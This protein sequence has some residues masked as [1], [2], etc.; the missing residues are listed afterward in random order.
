MKYPKVK[1]KQIPLK[2][3][4][5]V[6]NYF[7]FNANNNFGKYVFM[8]HP[9]LKN[10]KSKKEVE[11]YIIDLSRKNQKVIESSISVFR[12]KWQKVEKDFFNILPEI[13]G[14]EWPQGKIITA[15]V[16]INPISPRFLD[17]WAFSINYKKQSNTSRVKEIFM[18]EI[19]H[20]LY[21]KKWKEVFPKSKR[22]T[23]D[24]PYVE[25]RLSEILA[26][27]IL[28]YSPARKLIGKSADS[29]DEHEKIKIGN[30][31]IVKHFEDLYK[32]SIKQQKSFDEFLQ[33][34]YKEILKYESKF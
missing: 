3:E 34:A 14:T 31:S 7:V 5:E 28:N 26:P 4:L 11:K 8:E 6:L 2:L 23:F 16:S 29:Y 10:A 18:H 27:I 32:K 15:Y 22:R 20:F 13:M 19:V 21:F 33:T 17:K 12:K 25:W 24:Y 1:I 9:N 30:N